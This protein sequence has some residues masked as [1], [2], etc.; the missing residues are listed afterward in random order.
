MTVYYRFYLQGV[1][2]P[3]MV[4][5]IEMYPPEKRALIGTLSSVSWGVGV[6]ALALLAFLLPNW[7]HQ[8]LVLSIGIMAALPMW[9]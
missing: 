3:A 6:V 7:R 9:W 4:W 5:L 8:M 1:M 2:L